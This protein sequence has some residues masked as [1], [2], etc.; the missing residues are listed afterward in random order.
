MAD[1]GLQGT[2][3]FAGQASKKHP[4]DGLSCGSGVESS[5]LDRRVRLPYGLLTLTI[6]RIQWTFLPN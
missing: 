1:L 6:E 4:L 5:K 3:A 2:D